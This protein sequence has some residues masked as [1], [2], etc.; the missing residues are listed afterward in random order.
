MKSA[1][2][3]PFPGATPSIS[4]NGA[5]PIMSNAIVWA[6][7]NHAYCTPQST[8]CGPAVLYAYDAT[9]L[10]TELWNSSTTGSD[11]AGFAVKFTVPTVANGKVYI[12][13][14]G[15]DDGTYTSSNRGELDVYGLKPN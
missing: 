1:H 13:T 10:G 9:N 14:R 2:I 8:A 3:F 12:G 11:D 4:A 15:S 5:N 7:D 6:L